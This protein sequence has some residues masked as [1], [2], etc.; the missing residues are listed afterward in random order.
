MDAAVIGV[1]IPIVA[2]VGGFA[3]AIAGIVSRSRVRQLEIRE[4]IAMI[5][6]GM[7]PAPETDPRGFDRAMSRME[8]GH[9]RGP[10][11]HRR[12]GIILLA[13]GFGFIVL[14][15]VAA[16]ELRDA[17]GIGGM[18]IMIGLGFLALSYFEDGRSQEPPPSSG[19]VPPPNP[20][21]A[22]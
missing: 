21:P 3:V 4:R 18:L 7:V 12:V 20:P 5:E 19:Q 9:R 16:D 6:R 22:S 10:G 15:G 13:V 14:I 11:R 17:I 8:R 1:F 2:I